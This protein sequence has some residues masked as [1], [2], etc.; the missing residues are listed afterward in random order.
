MAKRI[1]CLSFNDHSF[2]FL[3][4]CIGSQWNILLFFSINLFAIVLTIMLIFVWWN[5]LSQ[6]YYIYFRFII[7]I[8]DVQYSLTIDV[9]SRADNIAFNIL[10]SIFYFFNGRGCCFVAIQSLCI[11][12][13]Y[14]EILGFILKDVHGKKLDIILVFRKTRR[15]DISIKIWV[16][17]MI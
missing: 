9:V 12:A 4:C 15:L 17:A 1:R 5:N 6:I 14:L 7:F 16:Y 11:L 8:L 2:N 13:K 10:N 3:L